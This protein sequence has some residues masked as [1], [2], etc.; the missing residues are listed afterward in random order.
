MKKV[1]L[2]KLVLGLSLAASGAL[3][4]GS[5]LS[6]KKTKEAS[7]AGSTRVYITNNWSLSDL[8]VHYW[9]SSENT[10][11][12]T[13]A[14]KNDTN[15][16]VYYYDLPSGTTGWQFVAWYGSWN[17]D[18][19]SLDHDVPSNSTTGYYIQDTSGDG[20]SKFYMKT[21]SVTFFT[22]SFNANGGSGTMTNQTCY[23]KANSGNS[24]KA[25]TFTRTG[26]DFDGWN[27]NAAGTG[28]SYAGGAH[29][30]NNTSGATVTLFAKWKHTS[31]RY[32]VGKNNDW[33]INSAV[34]MIHDGQYSASINLSFGDEIKIAYYNGSS[35]EYTNAAYENMTPNASAYHYFGAGANNAGSNI[36]CYAAGQYTFYYAADGQ[37]YDSYYHI[38]VAY[39]GSMTAQHLAAQL[40]GADLGE[41]APDCKD[42]SKFPAMK[43]IFL[44][45][46][47]S[48]KSTFQ[49]YENSTEDQFKNAYLRYVAWAAACG[50]KPWESGKVGTARI[51]SIGNNENTN[52]IAIIVII[53]LVSVTAIGGFFFIR[54]RR[55]N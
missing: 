19:Y 24:L 11:S 29:I 46:S 1:G 10:S 49:G 7:A 47:A 32:I 25:N 39:N 30:N 43:T 9:G 36:K 50:E 18:T 35:F 52:T 27:T 6:H 5:G 22:V 31:G 2:I 53:S 44:G 55:E 45:L 3:A 13:W 17:R 37:N 16:D 21:W 51:I 28:T 48:E 14:Y 42:S 40:M 38:S 41:N 12:C 26:Y 34:Y 33:T 8:R 4:V 15:E 23:C 20:G 54:K